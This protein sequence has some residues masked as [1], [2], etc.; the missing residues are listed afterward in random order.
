VFSCGVPSRLK[1][2]TEIEIE[3]VDQL[4]CAGAG[5]RR[6]WLEGRGGK[7]GEMGDGIGMGWMD[8]WH[9]VRCAI[10][11]EVVCV[12]RGGKRKRDG[13]CHVIKG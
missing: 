13:D 6:D 2:W 1:V 8:G 9:V 7:E 5:L 12:E 3:I 11:Y 10:E 4:C